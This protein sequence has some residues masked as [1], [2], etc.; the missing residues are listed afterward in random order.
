MMLRVQGLGCG[1]WFR[2][3]GEGSGLINLQAGASVARALG[4][5]SKY[6]G[7]HRHSPTS[8][9]PTGDVED[10]GHNS[11]VFAPGQ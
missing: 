8:F 3:E 7:T 9:D 6:P 11:L 10:A 1:L 5:S 4:V 2:V